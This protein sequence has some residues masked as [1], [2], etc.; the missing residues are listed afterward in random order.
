MGATPASTKP[1]QHGS[2][3]G[4]TVALKAVGLALLLALVVGL[5]WVSRP[6]QVA[7][8]LLDRV[9]NALG[10]Q[11]TSSGAAEYTLRGTPRL[12]VRDIVVRQPGSTEALLTAERVELSLPWSTVRARGA[13]LTVRRIELD[14]PVLDLAALQRWLDS[15]P[16]S[17]EVRIPTL[18]DGLQITRGTLIADGWSI[19]GVALELPSLAPGRAVRARVTARFVVGDIS[20]PLDLQVA[21]SEPALDAGLGV[22]GILE[23][24]TPGWRMPMELQL[25]GRLHDGDDGIGLDGFKLGSRARHIA[26]GDGVSFVFGLAGSLRYSGGEVTVAPLGAALRGDGVIPT[27]D[28]AG[29][30]AWQSELGLRLAGE[31]DD[32]PDAWPAL[33]PPLGQSDSPLPFVLEYRGPADFSGATSLQLARDDTRFDTSFHLPRVMQWI[34]QLDR[35]TPLP[36]LDG[37]LSTPRLDISGAV[38]EGVEIEFNSGADAP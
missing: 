14:A 9:G 35:G 32:W 15:R 13:D 19:D 12:A 36:P 16:P 22:A 1:S 23:V 3:R 5:H 6:D 33:P 7:G 29:N 34:D 10:L 21:L 18:T 31:L 28:A 25:S 2:R 11:I 38:L 24:I 26:G 30:F 17:G 37:T 27:F 8:I 4:R 20:V